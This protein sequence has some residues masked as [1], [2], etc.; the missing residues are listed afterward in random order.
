VGWYERAKQRDAARSPR[1]R[2]LIYSTF[3]LFLIALGGFILV[4]VEAEATTG[5]GVPAPIIGVGCVI[6]GLWLLVRVRLRRL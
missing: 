2:V 5:L 6:T 4:V 1:K 3:A